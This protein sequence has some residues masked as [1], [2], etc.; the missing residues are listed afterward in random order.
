MYGTINIPENM[1]K[2]T[3]DVDIGNDKYTHSTGL[4]LRA[5][6]PYLWMIESGSG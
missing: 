2:R 4:Y 3:L 6:A 1:I 5:S